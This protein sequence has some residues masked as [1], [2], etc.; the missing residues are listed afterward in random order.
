MYLHLGMDT[1]VPKRDIVG[2]FDTDNTTSSRITRN[3]LA[4]A[5]KSGNIV[6]ISGNLP[7]SFVLCERDGKRTVYL[8]QLSSHTLL[9]RSN[10]ELPNE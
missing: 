7:K 4:H 10:A 3:F 9:K 6:D 5:E 8:S 2:I 1:V